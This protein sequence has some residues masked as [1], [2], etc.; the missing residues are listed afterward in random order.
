MMYS[1]MEWNEGYEMCAKLST[2]IGT[3]VKGKSEAIKLGLTCLLAG[4]HLL[5]EDNPGTGKTL[6]AKTL[7]KLIT[8]SAVDLDNFKRVQFTP[9]LLPMDLIGTHIFNP[10]LSSFNFKKGPLFT[11]I[12]L[13]DEI[14]RASPKVQSALLECMAEQQ[15]TVAEETYRLAKPFFVVATQNPLDL[16][17]TF[18]LPV[19]Q[20]DRFAMKINFGFANEQDEL[21]IYQ[22][23]LGIRKAQEAL[24]PV[25][26]LADILLLQE[27]ASEVTI[28]ESVLKT[29]NHLV[30][31][32]RNR[33]G[34][35]SGASTRAGISIISCL[36]AYAF[37]SDRDF[38]IDD[39]IIAI[40]PSCLRHRLIFEQEDNHELIISELI[41]ESISVLRNKL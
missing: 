28:Q 2:A 27:K 39:D 29:I 21:M 25:L 18:P 3:I 15:I 4:E 7:A 36:K 8:D 19:A 13:A 5:I 22:Q 41:R 16:L 32:T 10:N 40:A 1:Q 23:Y 26:T 14:N 33:V 6:F 30:R 17:G 38:V 34:I 24:T 35:Q 9:D 31:A 20:L 11:N 37:L 12:L